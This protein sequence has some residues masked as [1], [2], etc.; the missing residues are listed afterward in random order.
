MLRPYVVLFRA[1]GEN[2]EWVRFYESIT[3]A[4]EHTRQAII[5]EYGDHK[6]QLVTELSGKEFEELTQQ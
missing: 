5:K 2:H 6:I 1:N 3:Q 4:V